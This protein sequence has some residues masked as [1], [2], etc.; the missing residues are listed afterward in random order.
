[1]KWLVAVVG[2]TCI[3]SL[4]FLGA[5]RTE[6]SGADWRDGSPSGHQGLVDFLAGGTQVSVLE[7]TLS[8][9]PNDAGPGHTLFLF[10]SHRSPSAAELRTVQAFLERGGT[11]VIAADGGKA[12]EWTEPLGATVLGLPVVHPPESEVTGC[13]QASFA[14]EGGLQEACLPSPS[15]VVAAESPGVER[16]GRL[17]VDVGLDLDG[18]Q[19]LELLDRAPNTYP[20]ALRWN[21][22]AGSVTLVSDA[23]L[24]RNAVVAAHPENLVFAQAL[25]SSAD[26]IFFDSTSS[27]HSNLGAVQTAVT[28]ASAE[29]SSRQ[30][31]VFMLAGGALV[32]AFLVQPRHH[33][34]R[35][36]VHGLSPAS[37]ALKN[38]SMKLIFKNQ[39]PARSATTRHDGGIHETKPPS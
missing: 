25:A 4:A 39:E 30:G 23:D 10:P 26:A 20:V 7:A 29:G 9:L 11:V 32:A 35:N 3:L 24:W 33:A 14:L 12:T 15:V 34:W 13:L 22:G 1:M 31:L 6:L 16:I 36:H 8:L 19:S 38:Q 2:L 28:Q 18:D 37:P 17:L 27:G 21:V 5:S